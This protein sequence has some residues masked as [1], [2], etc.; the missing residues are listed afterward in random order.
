MA[1]P[2]NRIMGD[3]TDFQLTP[4]VVGRGASLGDNLGDRGGGGRDSP[5]F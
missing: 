2:P 4:M 3:R 5:I 1:L